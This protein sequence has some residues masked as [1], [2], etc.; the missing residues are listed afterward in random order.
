[1]SGDTYERPYGELN[2]GGEAQGARAL[3][4]FARNG[5]VSLYLP[6]NMPARVSVELKP[7]EGGYDA[8]VAE[9][10]KRVEAGEFGA[11]TRMTATGKVVRLESSIPAAAKPTLR[12]V[13]AYKGEFFVNVK[14]DG[15]DVP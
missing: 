6:A 3:F 7:R 4:N 13:A 5:I 9:T 12:H 8:L 15:K 10:R 14:V 11:D 1:M 2:L